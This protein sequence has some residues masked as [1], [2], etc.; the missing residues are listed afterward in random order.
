MLNNKIKILF[1]TVL[2][3]TTTVVSSWSAEPLGFRIGDAHYNLVKKNLSGRILLRNAKPNPYSGG[4]VLV[5]DAPEFLGV[6]G[7]KNLAFI[8]DPKD[9]LSAVVMKINKQGEDIEDDPYVGFLNVFNVLKNKYRLVKKDFNTQRK[10]MKAQFK[11]DNGVTIQMSAP[12]YAPVFELR[13]LSNDF[14]KRYKS[15]KYRKTSEAE[16]VANGQKLGMSIY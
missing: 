13:Y 11:S 14:I 7:L 3:I 1:Y 12:K 16:L 15:I 5:S 9:K 8:F 10:S 6:E 2:T 4:K